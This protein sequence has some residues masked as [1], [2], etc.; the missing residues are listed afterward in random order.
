MLVEIGVWNGSSFTPGGLQVYLTGFPDHYIHN[1]A[2]TESSF[3]VP[4]G[5]YLALRATID[6]TDRDFDFHM[7][8]SW[9]YIS[10]PIG[11]PDYP[12]CPL[13]VPE[14]SIEFSST[15]EFTYIQL[16]WDAVECATSYNIY[17]SDDPYGTFTLEANITDTTW[18]D[19]IE[20]DD[21][22]KFYFVRA[23]GN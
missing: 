3:T 11:S 10:A 19:F 18:I 23:V 20:E 13:G 14:V 12:G 15:P 16:N 6:N 1:Y 4:L 7:G 2:S 9:A 8:G 5:Q 22:R 17:S 21:D